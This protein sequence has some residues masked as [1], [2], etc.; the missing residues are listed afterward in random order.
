MHTDGTFNGMYLLNRANDAQRE[1]ISNVFGVTVTDRYTECLF[2]PDLRLG[3]TG[4]EDSC[5]GNVDIMLSDGVL[6]KWIARQRSFE[7]RKK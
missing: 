7:V 1:I 4:T 2:H 6:S 5:L 3:F